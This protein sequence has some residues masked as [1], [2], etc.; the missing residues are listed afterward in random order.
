[1]SD[2]PLL[3]IGIPL[4]RAAAFYNTIGELLEKPMVI[5]AAEAKRLIKIRDQSKKLLVVAFPGSLSPA[6]KTC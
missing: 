6:I 1:M 3:S 5:N 4:Y 2:A